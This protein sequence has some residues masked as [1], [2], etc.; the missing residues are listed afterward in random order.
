M[1]IFICFLSTFLIWSINI[2]GLTSWSLNIIFVVVWFVTILTCIKSK[3]RE[4]VLNI[5]MIYSMSVGVI[6]CL[7]VEGGAY[8]SEIRVFGRLSGA[9]VRVGFT[10]LIFLLTT[11]SITGILSKYLQPVN[12]MDKKI[13]W[14]INMLMQLI[15]FCSF[16]GLLFVYAKY[17]TP[18]S[19]GVDRF[20]Y[21]SDIAPA[22][23]RYL[24]FLL[25]QFSFLLGIKYSESKAK[26]Y[27]VLL[28]ASVFMQFIGG[29]KFTGPTLSI[30]FFL[31]PVL[32]YLQ[33]DLISEIL[34]PKI[35]II[36][37]AV[38]S[39]FIFS[40]YLSYTAIYGDSAQGIR[41][42]LER[43]ALQAQV[44]WAVDLTSDIINPHLSLAWLLKNGFGLGLNEGNAIF[45]M[46][47]LMQ[48]ITPSDVFLR[49]VD[50]GIRFTMGAPVNYN[51]FFGTVLGPVVAIFFGFWA[52]FGT[53]L[54]RNAILMKDLFYGFIVLKYYY[55]IIQICIMSDWYYF[56]TAKFMVFTIFIVFYSLV[57]QRIIIKKWK[58]A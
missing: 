46:Y 52:G 15:I 37:L 54:L 53:W 22:W 5:I 25:L 12:T 33:K 6:C 47:F 21:W 40:S 24:Q 11:I 8:L 18:N 9:T 43:V 36:I 45:G 32:F 48:K 26:K 50:N 2:L 14:S 51:Y 35:I 16:L 31:I 58:I 27:I 10:A 42:L 23:G 19:N 29:E 20:K 39:I 57:L 28:M 4:S 17:G 1:V 38:V 3:N 55:F 56:F 34:R 41:Y 13:N 7:I 49:F 30:L 44:W